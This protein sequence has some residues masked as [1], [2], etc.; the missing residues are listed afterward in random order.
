MG[1]VLLK[2][3]RDR[4]VRNHH[5]WVF[6]GAVARVEGNPTDGD[7]VDVVDADRQF[8]AQGYINR[9]SQIVVR[10]LSWSA[11]EPVDESVWSNRIARSVERR[12]VLLNDQSTT[13][14]R[15]VYAESDLLPG[16]V[17]DR[18]GEYLVMQVLTLG[19]E[20]RRAEIV[21]TLAEL[22][23]PAG[24]FERSDVDVR[25]KE[26]LPQ[27]A[28]TV[29]GEE[30]P[31]PVPI[32]ENGYR[33]Q[34]DVQG[35]QKTGFYLDQ[36]GNRARLSA[37]SQGRR[38]LNAFAY[39]GGF[40]VYAAAGGAQSIV[41]VDTSADALATARINVAA[42][43]EEGR[44]DEYVVGDVFNVLRQ[45]RAEGRSFDLIVLDPPKF[46]YSQGQ[47]QAACRGYKDINLLAFQ[48]MPPGGI[49]FTLSCSGLIT[50]DL[51]QKVVF[52]ASIDAHRDVQVLE[53]LSQAADHPLLLTFPE[54]EYLKG[55]VCRVL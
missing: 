52:G 31:R 50:P 49:L 47:V 15:L 12:Q 13:A 5:P 18:Y 35:G 23:R 24:I 44:P 46:A 10:L 19:I 45:F 33:F 26:G 21:Q 54:G 37:Y 4:A 53:K 11:D 43:A 41:N 30:P 48:L 34:V 3:G 27:R 55:L 22:I 16:L 38:M 32:L 36:R 2:A 1:K 51:F 29:W 25:E 17:V 20:R 9:K 6:S 14:C 39:T 8:L 7:V 42:N 40:A 28:G